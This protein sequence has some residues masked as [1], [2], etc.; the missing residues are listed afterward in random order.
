MLSTLVFDAPA[1]IGGPGRVRASVPGCAGVLPPA[2]RPATELRG[3]GLPWSAL[4]GADRTA[5]GGAL[6]AGVAV[7]GTEQPVVIQPF[8]TTT[9]PYSTLGT[10]SPGRPQS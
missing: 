8:A 2:V 3:T 6:P 10:H 1:G 4:L 7:R 9:H 5:L